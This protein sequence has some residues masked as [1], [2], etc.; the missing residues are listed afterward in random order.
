MH[1]LIIP[2]Y[3]GL[4]VVFF[5]ISIVS[6]SIVYSCYKSKEYGNPFYVALGLVFKNI[7]LCFLMAWLAVTR[8]KRL[9]NDPYTWMADHWSIMA[10]ALVIFIGGLLVTN[11]LTNESPY[12]SL[13]WL[14]A[15]MG[16]FAFF[17]TLVIR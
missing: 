13:S 6:S 3:S 2:V 11:S 12:G 16:V 14:C 17:F 10:S 7:S 9:S 5:F 1:D 8:S 4:S 15:G